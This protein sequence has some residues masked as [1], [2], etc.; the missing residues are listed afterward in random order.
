MDN[1][2]SEN[3][4]KLQ[5]IKN[6]IKQAIIDKGV[7]VSDDFN[8]YAEAIGNISGG[9]GDLPEILDTDPLTFV[10]VD[11]NGNSGSISIINKGSVNSKT[12]EYNKNN[13]GWK[14]Y[15]LGD[16]IRMDYGDKLQFRSNTTV[17]FSVTSNSY[18]YFKTNGIY[19]CGGTLASLLNNDTNIKLSNYCFLRAFKSCSILTSPIL[20]WQSLG[21]SCYQYM[22]QNCISLVNAPELPATT[23][24]AS[25]YSYM[26]D[27]CTSLVNAPELPATTLANYCYQYMF[28]N[29]ISITQIKIYAQDI[30]ST[31]NMYYLCYDCISLKTIYFNGIY[32]KNP[33]IITNSIGDSW[34]SGTTN[35]SD[36]IFYKNPEWE[37]P[38]TRGTSTIPSNWQIVDWIQ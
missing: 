24:T 17:A 8:T 23:L 37:G 9:G 33:N 36:C 29:C 13:E 4:A 7:E 16:A 10:R 21:N 15:I 6:N 30:M 31:S 26:F 27:N 28:Q 2:I 5:Q 3:L 19:K 34:L 22:F 20:P 35:T 38:T 11:N 14:T 32:I 25:C 1:M 12:F 18:R